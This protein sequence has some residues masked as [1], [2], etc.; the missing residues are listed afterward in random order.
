M[1]RRKNNQ[2][3]S[4]VPVPIHSVPTESRA[5]QVKHAN[6]Q[7]RPIARIIRKVKIELNEAQDGS[8]T[9]VAVRAVP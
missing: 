6:S 2:T 9:T 3:K 7:Q 1:D 8:E 4:Y 5:A